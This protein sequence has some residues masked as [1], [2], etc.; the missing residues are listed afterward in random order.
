VPKEVLRT[1]TNSLV[2]DPDFSFEILNSNNL[3]REEIITWVR[4]LDHARDYQIE[5][6]PAGWA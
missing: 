2:N 3:A 5:L 1:L 4:I 6:A